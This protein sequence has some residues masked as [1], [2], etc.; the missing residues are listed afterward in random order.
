MRT[1]PVCWFVVPALAL[2]LTGCSKPESE[3]P[4]APPGGPPGTAAPAGPGTAAAPPGPGAAAPGTAATPPGHPTPPAPGSTGNEI[5]TRKVKNALIT[6]KVDTAHVGVSVNGGA[7]TLSGSVPNA[8]QK[9]LAV[10]AAK[11]VPEVTSVKDK[12]TVGGAK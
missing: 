11:R 12:L 2:A 6:S 8:E 4:T 1:S 9:A 7:I 5:M 10:A 3:T